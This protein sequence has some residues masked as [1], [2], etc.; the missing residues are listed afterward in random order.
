[1][2]RRRK[3]LRGAKWMAIRRRVLR[4][5]R[6][7][8][9]KCGAPA[10]EVHHVKPVAEGGSDAMRNLVALCHACHLAERPDCVAADWR[11]YLD[12]MV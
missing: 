5:D 8:C 3:R 2:A 11:A 9:R 4:R 7:K 10:T 6:G 12:S 1:M